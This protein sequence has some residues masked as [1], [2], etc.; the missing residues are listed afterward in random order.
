MAF[1]IIRIFLLASFNYEKEN[2]RKKSYCK[3][4]LDTHIDK[5]LVVRSKNL[6]IRE[7]SNRSQI[8]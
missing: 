4:Y 7:L 2:R 6:A 5:E 1:F 8:S 3:A